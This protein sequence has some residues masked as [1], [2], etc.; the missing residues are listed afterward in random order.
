[1]AEKILS[2]HNYEKLIMVPAGQPWQRPTI[3]N[4]H[5]RLEMVKL[6]IKSDEILVSD[7]EI[8]RNAPSYALDTVRE[9]RQ[10][11]DGDFT[12]IIGSDALG[13][14]ESW[15]E[16]VT[17]AGLVDFLV[18]TRPG[19]DIAGVHVPDYIRWQQIEIGA[20]DISATDIRRALHEGRDV[21]ALISPQVLS[22]IQKNQLYGAA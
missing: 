4:A 2:S 16:I 22:Y 5:H 11:F 15:H 20:L 6:A 14:L 7:C 8:R 9:L 13:S 19:F 10:E 18:I 12:W 3:A 21:S 1:M 17:L